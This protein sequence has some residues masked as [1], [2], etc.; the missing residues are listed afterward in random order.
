MKYPRVTAILGLTALLV[1]WPHCE[2]LAVGTADGAVPIGTAS[3]ASQLGVM[4]GGVAIGSAYAPTTAA[5][6]DG[7]IVSG[8][9]GIGT[10]TMNSKLQVYNGE[11]QVGS[12]GGSCTSSNAGAIRYTSGGGL[13]Y[14]N[15]SFWTNVNTISNTAGNVG[16]FVLS[17][18][19]YNA[20]L[21][22]LSGADSTCLTELT[23]NT[24]WL[25]YSTALSNGQLASGNV[26]AFLC[27]GPDCTLLIPSTTYNFAN[28]NSGSFG[29]A[30]FTTDSR[31]FGPSDSNNW[32]G[33]TYFGVSTE[34]WTGEFLQGGASVSVISY[35]YNDASCSSWSTTSGNTGG[36]GSS[37]NTGESRW[38]LSNARACSTADHLICLVQPQQQVVTQGADVGWLVEPTGISN[39]NLGGLSGANATCLTNLTTNTGWRGYSAANANGQLTSSKVFAFLCDGTTCNNLQPNTTYYFAN[40]SDSTA[41]GGSFTTDASGVGPNDSINWGSANHIANTNTTWSGRATTSNTAWANSSSA[42]N[43]SAWTSSS[44]GTNGDSGT[45]ATTTSSRWNGATVACSSVKSLLCFVN[46]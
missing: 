28:A 41:G 11:A 6:T 45:I 34:Y 21:G 10:A 22:G 15:G 42:N 19:T 26:R 12:G 9:V 7:L 37:N 4:G 38:Y 44:A 27:A 2:A 33:S 30:S 17:K 25:G 1:T 14:C 5:P 46:P 29:G 8:S 20:S 39:G 13:Q 3:T 35:G 24:G 16:Y 23:T 32:S 31:G 18:G 36:V 40:A 43:C